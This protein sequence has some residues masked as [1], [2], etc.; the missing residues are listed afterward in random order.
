[1]KNDKKLSAGKGSKRYIILLDRGDKS[2][3]KKIEKEFHVNITSSEDL[4]KDNRSFNILSSECSVFYKNLDVIVMEDIELERMEK[5]LT[6]QKSPVIYYEEERTFSPLKLVD[7][8]HGNPHFANELELLSSIKLLTESLQNQILELE[9][10]LISKLIPYTPVADMEWGLKA[11]G[12]DKTQYTGKG[13]DICILDTGFDLGHP[14]FVNRIIEGKSFIAGE[15]WDKDV[16]GHGTHCAGTAAGNIR[17][18]TGKRYGVAPESNLKIAKVL[19]DNGIGTTSSIIDAIDW[20]ITKKFRVISLSFGSPAKINEPPSLIFEIAGQK[21]M[22]NNCLLIAAAGNDSSR[23]S[24]PKPVSFPANS[25]SIMAVA[26][27]DEQLRIAKFSN[28]GINAATGGEINVCAPGVNVL[29]SYPKNK[30]NYNYSSGTSM[31]APHAS[32]LAAIYMEAEP[33]LTAKEIWLLLEE[34]AIYIENLKYRDI[35]K[36]LIQTI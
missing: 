9:D 6:D 30:G 1:M 26:A 25:R 24:I 5:S 35:G 34:N 19:S 14:D 22:E 36:G 2:S 33:S 7:L 13:V 18:D 21:A 28:G 20:A 17:L 23:P 3:L 31:A 15:A 16:N 12:L 10:V 8:N 27:I 29:S 4:S 11:I 32:G